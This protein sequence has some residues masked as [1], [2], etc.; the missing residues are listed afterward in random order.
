MKKTLYPFQEEAVQRILVEPTKAALLAAPMGAGKTPMAV[1]FV[2]RAAFEHPT[3]LVICP[4]GTR[5]S[6]ER[7][8]K[9]QG[10]K[11]PVRRITSTVDG[12]AAMADLKDGVAGVYLIGREYFRRFTWNTFKK[13]GVCIVDEYHIFT[14]RSSVGFKKLRGL[15]PEWKLAM[16]GTPWGNKFENAWAMAHWLWGPPITLSRFWGDPEKN[17][18]G[19]VTDYCEVETMYIKNRKIRKIT[20]EKNEGAFV[21]TLPCYIRPDIPPH[22]VVYDELFVELTPAQRKMY[23]KFEESNYVWL[24]EQ[25]L[26]EDMPLVVRIR[27]REMALGT[28]SMDE[29]GRT[30]FTDD[31]KSAKIDTLL[32]YL[33]DHPDESV[34]ILTHSKKYARIVAN[35]VKD[36]RLWVGDT[37]HDERQELIQGFGVD[38]KY[39]VATASAV[40]EGIDGLQHNCSTMIWL[41]R[42]EDN[43]L[44]KQVEAR[45]ARPTHNNVRNTVLCIDIL[46][47]DTHDESINN[48]L[49]YTERRNQASLKG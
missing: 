39:L 26:V 35:R 30:I 17:L 45:I 16:S 29:E 33:S 28:V 6:W 11:V 49:Y 32:E 46:A 8:F 1:E 43:V 9:G 25:A 44:N 31:M 20:G 42:T 48:S 21:K 3:V 13:V 14:N 41:S 38:F 12:K 4:L 37:S 10:L 5:V 23:D 7:T 18:N 36:S 19:F 15:K 24:G 47:K 27:L 22:P 40:A 2:R 34:L